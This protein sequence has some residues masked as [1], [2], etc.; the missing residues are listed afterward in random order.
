MEK[1][2]STSDSPFRRGLMEDLL[3][4]RDPGGETPFEEEEEE[5]IG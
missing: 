4:R 3:R 5:E 2:K 1:R